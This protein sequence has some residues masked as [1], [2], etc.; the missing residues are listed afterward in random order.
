MTRRQMLA[1]FGGASVLFQ[2]AFAS[3]RPGGLIINSAR[4]KDYEMPARGFLNW[5]T[6]VDEFFV[7]CHHY[8]PDVNVVD[9]RLKVDG[10]VSSPRRT[11]ML[12]RNIAAVHTARYLLSDETD[13]AGSA[14]IAGTA[15]HS[16]RSREPRFKSPAPRKVEEIS[17]CR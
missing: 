5:I 10:L 1:R 17:P 16:P 11:G 7:R 4:P 3:D 2:F 13:L 6:P 14:S 9:W 15:R 8:V 12:L